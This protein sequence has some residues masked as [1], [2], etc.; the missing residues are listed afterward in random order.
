MLTNYTR[1]GILAPYPDVTLANISSLEYNP[2]TD[3]FLIMSNSPGGQGAVFNND[4]STKIRD[5]SISINNADS[6]DLTHVSGNM[7]AYVH[8]GNSL[9][10]FDYVTS[11]RFG[12]YR[13]P[14]RTAS[15]KGLECAA[16]DKANQMYYVAQEAS[17][18]ILYRF[19]KDPSNRKATY[20]L[21]E[22][23][24]EIP[25][26][27][28]ALIS[29]HAS[30]V[31]GLHFNEVN[32]T[33]YFIAQTGD[34]GTIFEVSLDGQIVDTFTDIPDTDEVGNWEAVT[35]GPNGDIF[36]GSEPRHWLKLVNSEAEEPVV[37]GI[38]SAEWVDKGVQREGGRFVQFK[39]TD[40]NDKVH[41]LHSEYIADDNEIPTRM[42][43]RRA[44]FEKHLKKVEVRDAL[45]LV[46][47]GGNPFL[48]EPRYQSTDDLLKGCLTELLTS[49]RTEASNYS[50]ITTHLSTVSDSKLQL[51]LEVDSAKVAEIRQW[52]TD[53]ETIKAIQQKG[54]ILDG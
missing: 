5:F 11:Q 20:D 2:D 47:S 53:L 6:E 50:D 48:T 14:P 33:L 43:H 24:Y 42:A 44:K 45:D 40:H 3:E 8:E 10:E 27:L 35:K 12:K 34:N 28:E 31:A 30:H 39:F 26:D 13:L 23:G 29:P 21:R 18:M 51:L 38:S 37:K 25:F 9:E 1:D 41:V 15:N 7:I 54:V 32:N 17:P 36:V 52:Q 4:L 19:P 46:K 16:F 49:R 22:S